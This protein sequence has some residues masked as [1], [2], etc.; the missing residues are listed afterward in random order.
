MDEDKTLTD[1]ESTASREHATDESEKAWHPVTRILFRFSFVYFC[2]YSLSFFKDFFV[3]WEN[4]GAPEDPISRAWDQFLAYLAQHLFHLQEIR[5]GPNGSGD[6]YADYIHVLVLAVVSAVVCLVWTLVDRRRTHYRRLGR[7]L[8]VA[9]RYYL[10]AVMLS[11]GFAK[12]FSGQ[13]GFPPLMKLDQPLGQ[14]SPMGLLWT[15]MGYSRPYTFFAGLGEVVGGLLFMSRR[16]TTLGAMVTAGV[17][18]NVVMMNFSYDVPVKL[19]SSHLLLMAL[20]FLALDAKRL[21]NVLVWNRPAPATDLSPHF[22]H[23]R[24][25]VAGRVVK[26]VVVVALVWHHA[27]QGWELEQRF[28]PGA[29]K[30]PLWGIWDV[31]RFVLDGEERPPLLTDTE[32]WRSFIV[33]RYSSKV[34]IVRRMDGQIRG[35]AFEVDEGAGTARFGSVRDPD[36]QVTWTYRQGDPQSLAL[37][38]E[39]DG[40]TYRVEMKKRDINE[41]LLVHRGFHWI[42]EFPFNR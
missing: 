27:H 32:R 35:H 23:R 26:V 28:G 17:M 39:F 40:H 12:V 33:N 31:E 2:W 24:L 42:N 14:F 4:F 29:P 22:H 10:A 41:F 13:F 7:W 30:P 37:D 15:F 8:A 5:L 25:H 34:A 21:L 19:F 6:T 1:T 36:G 38:G 3:D 9:C 20:T 18:S 11:Y 16:T